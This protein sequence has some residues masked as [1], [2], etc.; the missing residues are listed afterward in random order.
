MTE[1]APTT[2]PSPVSAVLNGVVAVLSSTWL[3]LGLLAG[4]VAYLTVASTIPAMRGWLDTTDTGVY[5]WWPHVLLWL[6]LCMNL[7]AATLTRGSL[8]PAGLGAVGAHVGVLL[9]ALG[10]VWYITH[11]VEGDVQSFLTR[12]GQ[13]TPI[14]GF[15]D[16][17]LRAVNVTARN[18]QGN[19]QTFSTPLPS[20]P[21][22][23]GAP[24]DLTVGS[25]DADTRIRVV[26][27]R[28][29]PPTPPKQPVAAVRVHYGASEQMFLI[30]PGLPGGDHVEGDDFILRYA[31]NLPAQKVRELLATTQPAETKDLIILTAGADWP[32]PKLLWLGAKGLRGQFDA[33]AGQPVNVYEYSAT[34]QPSLGGLTVTVLGFREV[35]DPNSPDNQPAVR[36]EVVRAGQT[37]SLW[38]PLAW[39]PQE[40]MPLKVALPGGEL[41]LQF[42]RFRRP[43]PAELHVRE[44][45]YK[46]YPGSRMSQDFVTHLAILQ[47]GQPSREAEVRLNKPVAI[48][49]Y[50]VSQQGWDSQEPSKPQFTIL[51]VATRPGIGLVWLGSVLILLAMPYAF[52]VK[53]WLLRRNRPSQSEAEAQP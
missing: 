6:L 15:F 8:R 22:R 35:D 50:R 13:F 7:S 44:L 4:I 14:T 43:L 19:I 12:D 37:A 30:G 17:D 51:G 2:R 39:Y 40:Q 5:G 25:L 20:L 52:Y 18:A 33:P 45:E 31:P 46:A 27:Y 32:T 34:T 29:A 26:E 24:Q 16:Q 3:G 38:L 49:P 28:P 23:K 36:V 47:P 11:R 10:S 48:G 42:T 1:E 21:R 53:P 9:V 41:Y